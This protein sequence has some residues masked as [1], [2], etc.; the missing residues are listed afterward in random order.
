MRMKNAWIRDFNM[1]Y[2]SISFGQKDSEFPPKNLALE[3]SYP[4]G[5]FLYPSLT[6][7]EAIRM[8]AEITKM[9]GPGKARIVSY[10]PGFER[11]YISLF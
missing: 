2:N 7:E 8:Y 4:F 3:V 9:F 10:V 5:P 11:K 1:D 6:E